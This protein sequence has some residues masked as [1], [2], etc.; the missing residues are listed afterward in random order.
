[1]DAH[2]AVGKLH[3]F[4]LESQNLAGAQA[5]EEHQ[6]HKSQITIG[7][8]ALPELRDFFRRQR[9][10]DPPILFEAETPGDGQAGPAVAERGSFWITAL[11]MHFSTG[12]LFP[13][14][15]AIA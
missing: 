4:R 9:H 12:Y 1:M 3:V 15:S 2:L 11:E 7:A 14:L 10:D 8:E 5:V 13:A 6:A